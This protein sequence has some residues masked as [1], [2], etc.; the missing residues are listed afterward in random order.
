LNIENLILKCKKQDKK[1]QEILYRRFSPKFFV[2][3]LKYSSSYDQA[4]DSLD[5]GFIKIFQNISKYN[6]RGSFEGWMTRVIINNALREY[7]NKAVFITIEE[8]YFEEAEIEIE[9]EELSFDFLM[10]LIQE[11]PNQYRVVFNLYAM[12]GYSHKEISKLLN[13]SIGTSKSNLARA[14]KKLKENIESYKRSK[15]ELG[16]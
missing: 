16:L 3:C 8:E 12:D 15:M 13:I 7:Q 10:N 6:E 14:R 2:L 9:V 11:L 1:A 5:D 4:K